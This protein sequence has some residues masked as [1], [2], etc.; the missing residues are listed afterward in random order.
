MIRIIRD[1]PI[2]YLIDMKRTCISFAIMFAVSMLLAAREYLTTLGLISFIIISFIALFTC[3]IPSGLSASSLFV[4]FHILL[5]KHEC[6]YEFIVVI[7]YVLTRI[8]DL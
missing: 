2:E 6:A 4:L 5:E 8:V 3:S 7:S 1:E